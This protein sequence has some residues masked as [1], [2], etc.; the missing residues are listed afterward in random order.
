MYLYVF[1]ISNQEN[2]AF[3]V[4]FQMKS[5]VLTIYT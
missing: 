2:E 5:L 4:T 3:F 1:E